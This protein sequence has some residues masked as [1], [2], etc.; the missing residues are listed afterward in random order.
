M[1]EKII[2]G[3]KK[4]HAERVEKH[5]DELV[6]YN[7]SFAQWRDKAADAVEKHAEQIRR[8]TCRKLHFYSY[9]SGQVELRLDL[10]A[11]PV[12]PTPPSGPWL[13][14]MERDIKLLKMSSDETIK[15][16]SRS[17]FAKYF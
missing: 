11:Q 9:R 1:I 4:K 7:N 6:S 14:E 15:I 3:E 5:K 2:A 17:N 13:G 8:G 16:T 12:A 10:P